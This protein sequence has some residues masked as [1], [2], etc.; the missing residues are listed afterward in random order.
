[1]IINEITT[2]FFKEYETCLV[3]F[4]LPITLSK[5]VEFVRGG[6]VTNE[7]KVVLDKMNDDCCK[8]NKC[9]IV[10]YYTVQSQIV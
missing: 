4:P 7:S 8:M 10:L 9:F 5:I 3:V 6:F 1:M 2:S